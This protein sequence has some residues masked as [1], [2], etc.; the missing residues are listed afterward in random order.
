L[1]FNCYQLG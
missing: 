1:K